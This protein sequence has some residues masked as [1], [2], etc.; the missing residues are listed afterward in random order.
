MSTGIRLSLALV[1]AALCTATLAGGA[2]S[3]SGSHAALV[4]VQDDA[5]LQAGPGSIDS[6]MDVLTNLGVDIVRFTIRWDQVALDEPDSARDA[7][8][9]A[10]RWRSTDAILRAL[11]RSGIEAVVTLNGTPGW[12]NGGRGPNWAPTQAQSFADF[13]HAAATRY[14]WVRRWTVWNE[15]NRPQ[16]LRP[17]AAATYVQKLLNPAYAQIHAA[18]PDALVGGG[19]TA[20]RAGSGG[21]P[22]G[23]WIAGMARAHAKLD[24]YAH[25]PYPNRPQAETPSGPSC[26]SCASITMA[27]LDRLIRVV[28]ERLGPKRIWLTEFGYQTNPP[29]KY[30]G[31]PPL[32]QANYVAAAIRR[33]FVADDVD[34]LIFFLVRDDADEDGWQSG[35][36]TAGGSIKPS[37][38]AFRFPLQ[39]VSRRGELVTLWGQIRPGEGVQQYRLRMFL[40]DTSTW[41]GGVRTTNA[42]G[43]VSVSVRAPRGSLLKLWSVRDRAYGVEVRV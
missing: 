16:W 2:E 24:A 43:V 42:A 28:H 38:N 31:V 25:H 17:T 23:D 13:V 1:C 19:M 32:T 7:D 8:D 21:V 12:A 3:A 39:K 14:S 36:Y 9:P 6:K 27:D 10:Y 5:W 15:P 40:D 4:G 37:Y 11:R 34:M 35:F 22:P 30:L 20:P 33:V 18:I 26:S 41:L 29:D